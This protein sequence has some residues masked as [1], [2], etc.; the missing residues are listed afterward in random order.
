MSH[1]DDKLGSK[2][3]HG[4]FNAPHDRRGNNISC[5]ADDKEFSKTAV[6]HELRRGARVG[7]GEDHCKRGLPIDKHVATALACCRDGFGLLSRR[8]W[9][10]NASMLLTF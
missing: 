7:A 3:S 1:H 4:K 8:L 2:C 6:E 10:A 5:H 9:L